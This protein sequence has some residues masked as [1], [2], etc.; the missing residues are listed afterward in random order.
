MNKPIGIALVALGIVLIIFGIHEAD[1]VS[2]SFSKF[3]TGNPTDKSIWFLIGG[4]VSLVA[5][6][7]MSLQSARR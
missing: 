4:V 3:F 7:A 2:S 6:G 5:G 1:S